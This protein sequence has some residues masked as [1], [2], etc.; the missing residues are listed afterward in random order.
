MYEPREDSYLLK[1]HIKR[2]VTGNVLDIG[3]G[4]GILALEASRYV[5]R[6]IAT[7]IDKKLIDNLKNKYKENKKIRFV[8]SDLFK[9]VKGKFNLILFNPPYLPKDK[10]IKDRTIYGGK[11]GNELIQRFLNNVKRHLK[12]DGKILL[13]FSSLTNKNKIIELIKRNKL[14]FRQIDK[15][16]IFFEELYVY[17]ISI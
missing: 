12:K 14:K 1:R 6:I 15:K 10:N 4:S 8:Y 13:V 9:K 2:Y 11:K 17:L 5:K 7:D 16:K 3:T